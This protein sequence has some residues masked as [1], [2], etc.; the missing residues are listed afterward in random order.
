LALPSHCYIVVAFGLE[1]E[2]DDDEVI[3]E[4]GERQALDWELGLVHDQDGGVAL[5]ER[6]VIGKGVGSG[7]GELVAGAIVVDPVEFV[8][9]FLV[10]LG[11]GHELHEID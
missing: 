3:P 11:A 8:G 9:F 1:D 2:G 5:D 4:A 7:R 10:G 6:L